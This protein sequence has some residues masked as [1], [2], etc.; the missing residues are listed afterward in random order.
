MEKAKINYV[1][2]DATEPVGDGVKIIA[3]VCNNKY[4]WGAGFVLAISNKWELPEKEYRSLS[5]NKM[6]LGYVQKVV[7][8]KGVIV[9]NMI[10]QEDTK[11]NEFGV[12]P[13]RYSAI[14]V[15]LKDVSS[16][17]KALNASIHLVKIGCGLA[18]GN[19]NIMEKVIEESIDPSIN[20]T[21]YE[22]EK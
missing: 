19:W 17:A 11:P 5:K 8:E 16:L 9:C 12:P 7:V 2:G 4:R 14:G 21:V 6:K 3:H 22:F 13:I 18:G 15:A 10:G 20:V 1:K